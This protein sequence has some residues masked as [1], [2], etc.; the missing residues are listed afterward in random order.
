MEFN[1][2][3]NDFEK[4]SQILSAVLDYDFERNNGGI[5]FDGWSAFTESHNKDRKNFSRILKSGSLDKLKKML[6]KILKR[7]PGNA[8]L[9]EFVYK[10]TGYKIEFLREMHESIVDIREVSV[11]SSGEGIHCLTYV[12]IELRGGSGSIYCIRGLHPGLNAYWKDDHTIV[13]EIPRER[14]EI[15]RRQQVSSFGYVINIEYLEK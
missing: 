15:E 3:P 8:R 11:H 12:V 5:V 14:E 2:L 7:Y 1:P 6:E 9:A 13:I 4:C 10:R